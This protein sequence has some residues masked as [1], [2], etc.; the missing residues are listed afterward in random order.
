[1]LLNKG[2][3][4]NTPEVQTPPNEGVVFTAVKI[5]NNVALLD[6]VFLQVSKFAM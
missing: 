2:P 5:M 3:P 6:L 4:R 1:M